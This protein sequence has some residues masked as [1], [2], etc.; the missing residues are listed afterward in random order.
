MGDFSGGNFGQKEAT[1]CRTCARRNTCTIKEI[2]AFEQT[3]IRTSGVKYLDV[4][5]KCQ[6]YIKNLKMPYAPDAM[7]SLFKL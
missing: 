1:W 3:R 2:V 4:T 5:V 6:S 7:E